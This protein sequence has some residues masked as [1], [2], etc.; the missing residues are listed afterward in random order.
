MKRTAI[1]LFV[2][3]TIASILGAQ[4]SEKGLHKC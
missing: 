1:V 3:A 4:Q 2:I